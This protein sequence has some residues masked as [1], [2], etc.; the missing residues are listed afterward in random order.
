MVTEALPGELF[1]VVIGET[2]SPDRLLPQSHEA[3]IRAHPL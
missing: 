2:F 3:K 1:R